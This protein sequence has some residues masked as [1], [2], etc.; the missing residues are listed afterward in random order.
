MA[1][2]RVGV[3]LAGGRSRRMGGGDKCLRPLAGR[4][5]LRHAIDRAAPQVDTLLINAN[6]ALDRFAAFG[7]P[8]IG[9]AVSGFVGPL[10]GILSSLSW[11]A[12]HRPACTHVVSFATD[13]P[14]FP[15]DLVTR[16][17]AA[18]TAGADM[19][20]AE[21]GG[22][23][24]PVF[25]LWPVRLGDDLRRALAEERL[26]KVEDWIA[27][28]ASARVPFETEPVDPFFNVNTP[29]DL[30]AAETLF[31]RIARPGPGS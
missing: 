21:S 8:V 11:A 17:E 27:R 22:R 12:E 2:D 5:L 29:E 19:A 20:C 15:E 13:V 30:A 4:P 28:F 18:L 9:D 23:M 24:Q 6:G 3:L 31:N 10:A 7:L 1:A 25:G 26:Y 14:F 16:L